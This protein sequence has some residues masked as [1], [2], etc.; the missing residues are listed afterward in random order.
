[1]SNENSLPNKTAQWLAIEYLAI[2]WSMASKTPYLHFFLHHLPS[3]P[4]ILLYLPSQLCSLSS[5]FFWSLHQL[6]REATLRG[7]MD[8]SYVLQPCKI[9]FDIQTAFI[10]P[11]LRWESVSWRRRNCV[12]CA[13]GMGYQ[14]EPHTAA[15][16]ALWFKSMSGEMV[17]WLGSSRQ[18]SWSLSLEK[19]VLKSVCE[20]F[21]V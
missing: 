19:T 21:E 3:F 16:S 7:I 1:M 12:D 8:L 4:D 14:Y 2:K 9:H 11:C 18:G 15:R 10:S 13:D 20:G 17:V 6:I 5:R